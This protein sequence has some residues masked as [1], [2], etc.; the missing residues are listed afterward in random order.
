[1]FNLPNIRHLKSGLA[2]PV[3]FLASTNGCCKTISGEHYISESLLNELETANTTIDVAGLPWIESG[4]VTS[5]GKKSL[6]S[7]ILCKTHNEALSPIDSAIVP[8]VT[9]LQQSDILLRSGSGQSLDFQVDGTLIER[10]ILKVLIGLAASKQIR[11]E[12]HSLTFRKECISLLCSPFK[13]WPKGWGL[14]FQRPTN[15]V[16]HSRSFEFVPRFNQ[17]TFEVYD[18]V[19]RFNGFP[20]LLACGQPDQPSEYGVYRPKSL[21]LSN[22][23]VKSTIRFNWHTS[24]NS[25]MQLD[26]SLAGTYAGLPPGQDLPRQATKSGKGDHC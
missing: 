21:C 2:N 6:V 19:L 17:E 20:F 13:Q 4:M 25:G 11:S 14:Y 12:N 16:H 23:Q 10:W 7:N 3:C 26:L 18:C 9:A 24:T 1:M 22:K 8:L 15:T 5:V